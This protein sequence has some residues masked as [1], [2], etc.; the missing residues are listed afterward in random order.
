MCE[1]WWTDKQAAEFFGMTVRSLQAARQGFG[2]TVEPRFLA[3]D[4]VDAMAARPGK[5]NRRNHPRTR[6]TE[7]HESGGSTRQGEK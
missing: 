5:G 4:L 2:I 3:S 7:C 6:K 1:E